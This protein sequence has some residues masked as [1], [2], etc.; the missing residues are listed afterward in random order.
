[1]E[2]ID[3]ALELPGAIPAYLAEAPLAALFEEHA[4]ALVGV[5]WALI[6]DRSGAEDIVQEAFI[7]LRSAWPRLR[8]QDQA[9]SYLRSTVVNLARSRHRHR[10]VV[11]RHPDIAVPDAVSAEEAGVLREDQREVVAAVR[12]LSRRQRECLVLRYY[13]ELREAEIASALGISVNSV[14]TY[15]ARG[16]V[17]LER[18]LES[19]R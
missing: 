2:G 15:L 11:L 10:L 5:A 7:R 6:G 3:V 13:A 8:E 16:L 14:K 4:Q 19:S 12:R 9:G 17:S 1:V 18:K